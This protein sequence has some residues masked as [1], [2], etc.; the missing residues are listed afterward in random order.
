MP[1]T[2]S[3]LVVGRTSTTSS[4]AFPRASA[5]SASRIDPADAD[6][7]ARPLALGEQRRRFRRA[8]GKARHEQRADLRR[9]DAGK[10]LAGGDR[11]LVHQIDRDA[12]GRCGRPR[13]GARLQQIERAFLYRELDVLNIPVQRLQPARGLGQ[14][15][16]RL[17]QG[18]CQRIQP[19]RR[20]LAGDHVLALGAGEV[21]AVGLRRAAERVAAEE[22]AG[23]ASLGPGCRTPSPAA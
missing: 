2:S 3:G 4:P 19:L 16:V 11:S 9:A 13:G 20:P 21:F 18:G 10:R 1:C 6:A 5:S 7:G 14:G 15:S 22:H 12:D 8:A 17:R 23:P